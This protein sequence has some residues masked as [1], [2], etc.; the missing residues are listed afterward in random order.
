[1][2]E[3]LYL[4]SQQEHMLSTTFPAELEDVLTFVEAACADMWLSGKPF[5]TN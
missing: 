5:L 3:G 4:D 2:R 1:M